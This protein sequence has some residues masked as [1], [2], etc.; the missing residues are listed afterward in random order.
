MRLL[1]VI[2][3]RRTV[4]CFS[5]Q[6]GPDADDERA[7]QAER[8]AM[9]EQALAVAA[10]KPVGR[11]SQTVVLEDNSD[12]VIAANY[13]LIAFEEEAQAARDALS[14]PR[15]PDDL[16][17]NFTR[18]RR[19]A[20]L[21]YMADHDSDAIPKKEL[22]TA[23]PP[24]KPHPWVEGQPIG[25]HIVHGDGQL[26]TWGHGNVG[27]DEGR[28]WRDIPKHWRGINFQSTIGLT[29]PQTRGFVNQDTVVKHSLNL[30]GRGLFATH[31]IQKGDLIMV[32]K[33]SAVNLGFNSYT[34]RLVYMVRDILLD[35]HAKRHD[36]AALDYLHTWIACGQKSARVEYWPL[37]ATKR[38][39]KLV[40]GRATLDDLE[41]HEHH[42]A[43]I[44]A[45]IENN[46]FVV[47][48]F[49]NEDKGKGYWPEAGLLNHS[50]IPN[51]EYE[52][53]SMDDFVMSDYNPKIADL[54]AKKSREGQQPDGTPPRTAAFDSKSDA[55]S[56]A[57]DDV[58][59]L[60]K[61]F[62]KGDSAEAE[63][64]LDAY[65]TQRRND[66][67]SAMKHLPGMGVEVQLG[68][69][70]DHRVLRPSQDAVD[71]I[72]DDDAELTMKL[73]ETPQHRVATAKARAMQTIV[74]TLAP[75]TEDERAQ[76][77]AD[78][79]ALLGHR[80]ND[81]VFCCR[82]AKDIAE[83]EEVLIAYV[84]PE[85]RDEYREAVLYERY[86]FKCRCP[87]CAPAVMNRQKVWPRFMMF[88]LFLYFAMQ[89]LLYAAQMDTLDM[90]DAVERGEGELV[91]AKRYWT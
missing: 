58:S 88:I 86:R 32:V 69:K 78:A 49:Y 22:T 9:R 12:E 47:E 79:A 38:V 13:A 83:G 80:S 56:G 6:I 18:V 16:V 57:S 5:M 31:P 87:K 44:A 35:V 28:E 40:G 70:D 11:P 37:D 42:I 84:P 33:S 27:F 73:R 3:A 81:Y 64:A 10:P 60:L 52:V 82:A 19:S 36:A 85:W 61:A 1:R 15:H 75:E 30:T 68:N 62:A 50:C 8:N 72:Q 89:I 45:V 26:N 23:L 74:E 65:A 39:V 34:D 55:S 48:G 76:A 59:S 2:A 54:K 4:R 90:N 14:A 91:H 29:P 66:D 25:D 51:A 43:R 21:L 63:A 46:A 24:P 17:P 53:L 7:M 67:I 41:L 77:E 71:A 20:K